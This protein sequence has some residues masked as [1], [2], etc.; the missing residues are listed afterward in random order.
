M[1]IEGRAMAKDVGLP[2]RRQE[3]ASSHS[4]PLLRCPS[5]HGLQWVREQHSST[6]GHGERD[7]PYGSQD[8]F[9]CNRCSNIISVSEGFHCCALCFH[10]AG[11]QHVVCSVCSRDTCTKQQYKAPQ[12][13]GGGTAAV[14]AA[15]NLQRRSLSTDALRPSTGFHVNKLHKRQNAAAR[16]AEWSLV[17]AAAAPPVT[18]PPPRALSDKRAL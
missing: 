4:Q 7:Q 16:A 13:T 2:N 9:R 15:T 18:L 1:G 17:S 11:E 12:S 5:G 3:I 14:K 6:R 10:D 8:G